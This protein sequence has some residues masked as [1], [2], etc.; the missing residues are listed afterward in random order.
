MERGIIWC[1]GGGKHHGQGK[2]GR[3]DPD[4]TGTITEGRGMSMVMEGGFR[5]GSP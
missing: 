3:R 4:D 1:G 2:L 5:E